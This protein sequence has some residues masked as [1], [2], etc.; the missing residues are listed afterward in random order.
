[1]KT[2]GFLIA[3]AFIFFAGFAPA[4][5]GDLEEQAVASRPLFEGAQIGAADSSAVAAGASSR[6]TA[7]PEGSPSARAIKRV[8]SPAAK[9]AQSRRGGAFR[10]A[11]AAMMAFS[12]LLA[13]CAPKPDP[14][15]LSISAIYGSVN[16]ASLAAAAV[17]QTSRAVDEIEATQQDGPASHA[18]TVRILEAREYA[19]EAKA[20]ADNAAKTAKDCSKDATI[21]VKDAQWLIGQSGKAVDAA[22]EA[23][24]IAT[25]PTL[26]SLGGTATVRNPDGTTS[27]VE[28]PNTYRYDHAPQARPKL[29]EAKSLSQEI[30]YVAKMLEVDAQ[31]MS[32]TSNSGGAWYHP[33]KGQ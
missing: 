12:L 6:S 2:S 21:L 23:L 33:P 4:R 11:F 16:T 24:T 10:A 13:A 15:G 27:T 1:M 29:E 17:E 9:A 26:V 18:A 19:A 7:K 8:P 14:C 32:T 31:T 22:D 5:A 25:T 28:L 3:L 30:T 20:K